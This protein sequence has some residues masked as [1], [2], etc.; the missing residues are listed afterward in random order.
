M[1]TEKAS[2]T[3]DE[4]THGFAGGLH[5]VLLVLGIIFLLAGFGKCLKML[6]I[7]RW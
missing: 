4:N 6:D 7:L 2:T 1:E 3:G 5:G